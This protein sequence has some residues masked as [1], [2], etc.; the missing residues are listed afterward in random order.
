MSFENMIG[1]HRRLHGVPVAGTGRHGRFYGFG[2]HGENASGKAC[3]YKKMC[4]WMP[5]RDRRR[6]EALG[7]GKNGR[8]AIEANVVEWVHVGAAHCS[9][10]AIWINNEMV[11]C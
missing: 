6:L 7:A 10:N 11:R 3:R 4:G 8:I 5:L 1:K 2:G 9:A